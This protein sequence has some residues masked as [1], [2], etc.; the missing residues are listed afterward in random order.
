MVTQRYIHSVERQW[1][2][3]VPAELIPCGSL[4]TI[5]IQCCEILIFVKRLHKFKILYEVT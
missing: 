2:S 5:Q 3:S 1:G 4:G